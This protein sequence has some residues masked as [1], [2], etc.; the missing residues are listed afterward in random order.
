VLLN[1]GTEE[2][3]PVTFKFTIP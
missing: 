2:I 3:Q 1:G